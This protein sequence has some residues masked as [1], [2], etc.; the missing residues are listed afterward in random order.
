MGFLQPYIPF[1]LLVLW[2]FL[3]IG[4]FRF[5][6]DQHEVIEIILIIVALYGAM[7]ILNK[8]PNRYIKQGVNYIQQ[9][10]GKF[11]R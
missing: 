8:N 1:V 11:S 2:V 7:I 3:A 5:Y 10:V 6:R 4:F 9:S